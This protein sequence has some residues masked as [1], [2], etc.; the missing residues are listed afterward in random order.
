VKIKGKAMSQDLTFKSMN[1]GQVAVHGDLDRNS[2]PKAWSERSQW[3]PRSDEI[4]LDLSGVQQVDSAG[5]AMLIR[6]KSELDA[7]DQVLHL[8]NTNIQLKQ[9]AEVSGVTDLLSLS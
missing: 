1:G 4:V 2:V 9:F 6:L 7:R 5:L 3:V 8:H